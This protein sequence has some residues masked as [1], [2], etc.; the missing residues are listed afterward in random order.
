MDWA[1]KKRVNRKKH[2][3]LKLEHRIEKYELGEGDRDEVSGEEMAQCVKR[4]A[5]MA[6]MTILMNLICESTEP[7]TRWFLQT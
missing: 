1:T 2:S 4:A 6:N 5:R 7:Y 3:F